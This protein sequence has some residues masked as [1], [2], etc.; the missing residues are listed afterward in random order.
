MD[1]NYK[2]DLFSLTAIKGV[3]TGKVGRNK[4]EVS[5][6]QSYNV[7]TCKDGA[8]DDAPA[9][10]ETATIVVTHDRCDGSPDVSAKVGTGETVVIIGT[11]KSSDRGVELHLDCTNRPVFGDW[12]DKYDKKNKMASWVSVGN[13]ARASDCKS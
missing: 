10:G 1:Q 2:C 7:H 12:L 5:V 6:S 3:V 13:T 11:H 8:R 9:I 4:Y